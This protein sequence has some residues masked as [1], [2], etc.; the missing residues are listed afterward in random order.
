M[1][2]RNKITHKFWCLPRGA[3]AIVD[4]HNFGRY[5]GNVISDTSGFQACKYTQALSL[6]SFW[7]FREV[8][9][10]LYPRVENRCRS[11]QYQFSSDI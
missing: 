11:I 9:Y 1:W 2:P 6:V 8:K 3:Y 10:L 4:P 5:Y 7:V